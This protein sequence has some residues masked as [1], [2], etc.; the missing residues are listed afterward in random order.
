MEITSSSLQPHGLYSPLNSSGQNTGVGSVS[1]LQ[2]IF[3]TQGS[4][5]GLLHCRWILYQL[6]HKGSP[7]IL[8]WVAHPFSS[9]SSWLRNWTRVPY[10][11]GGFF[12]KNLCPELSG[13]PW[14]IST[15]G[16]LINNM[17]IALV[18]KRVQW[19]WILYDSYAST[20]VTITGNSVQ[21]IYRNFG[22]ELLMDREAWRAVIHGV[23]KGWTR[24]SGLSAW[25]E[26]NW[27]VLFSFNGYCQMVLKQ[28]IKFYSH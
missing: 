23:A 15:W 25:T 7:R 28:C 18:V 6:S 4:N 8:E 19:C 12:T 20:L 24:L 27:D 14:A 9:G 1:L 10:I 13:E 3:P 5:P 21:Y 17:A 22:Q 2:G 26:L 11:A 16:L